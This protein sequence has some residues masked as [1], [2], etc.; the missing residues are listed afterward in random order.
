MPKRDSIVVLERAPDPH[1]N[2][3]FRNQSLEAFETSLRHI[4]N[5]HTIT[6]A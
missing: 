3:C 1:K 4:E 2:G 6:E 5:G